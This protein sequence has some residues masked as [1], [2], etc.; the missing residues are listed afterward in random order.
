MNVAVM[1]KTQADLDLI[2]LNAEVGTV[3]SSDLY[4]W[5][6]ESGLPS[7]VAIRLKSLID[8]TKKVADQ[9]INIGK[10]ILIKII[11]FVKE[12]P[13][14]ATGIAV[15]VA[16]GV[17]ASMVPFLGSILSPIAIAL[18]VSVGAIV[19]HRM[20]KTDKENAVNT[21]NTDLNLTTTV[22]QDI[23]EI[24]RYFFELLIDIFN[25]AFDESKL[26][27]I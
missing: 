12:H 14:L 11:E 3:A 18:G 23:I 16:L 5:L 25:T 1:T 22:T 4:I 9:V 7:E 6:R 8:T 24:A 19:G 20:D 10:I 2:L 17:I 26:K 27:G 15:G 13:N 21:V